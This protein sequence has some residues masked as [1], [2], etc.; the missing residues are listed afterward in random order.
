MSLSGGFAGLSPSDLLQMLS[1]GAK[2]GL[3]T[4]NRNEDR[5]HVFLFQGDV[6]GVTSS[7][8]QGSTWRC[9][10]EIGIRDGRTV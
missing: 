4:C 6:V 9:L 7:R 8:Y 2:T 1:W 10:V 3:L 5:R